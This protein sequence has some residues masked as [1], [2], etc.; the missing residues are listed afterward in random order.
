MTSGALD[1]AAL[2]FPSAVRNG[3]HIVAKLREHLPAGATSLLEIAAGSGQHSIAIARGVPQLQ[4]IQPTD[5]ELKHIDSITAW[6][7][8]A[9]EGRDGAE[10]IDPARI[11]DPLVLDATD[12]DAFPTAATSSAAGGWDAMLNV[13]M[14][15]ISPIA[16]TQGLFCAA[17]RILRP[18]GRLFAYGPYMIDGKP[19]TESN[20]E[21]D[22]SLKS[23]NP[24]WGLRDLDWVKGIAAAQGLRFLAC[25]EMPANNF[26]VVYERE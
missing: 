16:A 26:F 10:T 8:V 12:P 19:T 9:A 3:P 5:L 17:G 25:E 6:R 23:R 2:D 21:F 14:I 11:L 4:A 1:P 20:A 15:H 13:N 22:R 24:E 18:G 7:R